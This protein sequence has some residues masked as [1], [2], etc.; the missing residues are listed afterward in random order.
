MLIKG[1]Y[2]FERTENVCILWIFYKSTVW[3]SFP[4]FLL[5]LHSIMNYSKKKI[6][7][8]FG[9]VK[10]SKRAPKNKIHVFSYSGPFSYL[11][12]ETNP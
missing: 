1:V 5:S 4:V 11:G 10:H 6:A 8:N 2:P 9:Y 12:G 7:F 3:W